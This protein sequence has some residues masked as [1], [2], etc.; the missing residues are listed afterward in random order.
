MLVLLLLLP[1]AVQAQF[2][3]TTNM[4]GENSG[5]TITGYDGPGG[6][7][8][9]PETINGLPVNSIE[10]A[11]FIG[12]GLTSLTIG[13]NLTYVGDGAFDTCTSLTTIAVDA[14]NSVYSSLGGVLFNKSQT[15]LLQYPGG[16]TGDY[17]IPSTVASIGYGAF[18][19]CIGVTS[20]T[21]PASVTNI[22]S[23]SLSG[24]TSLTT[25]TVEASNAVYS[26][27][28]GVLFNKSQTLLIQY[29][30]GQAGDYTIPNTVTSIEDYAF[31]EC[32]ALTNITIPTT[33]TS[34]GNP[35]FTTCT[36]LTTITVDSSNA[37]YSSLGGVLFNKSQTLLIQYPGGQAGDYTIPNTVT[38]IGDYAFDACRVLTNITVPSSVI[39]IGNYAFNGCSALTGITI[40]NG[41]TSIGDEA[42]ASCDSLIKITIPASVTSLGFYVFLGSTNLT[43]VYFTGNVP[44]SVGPGLFLG[45]NKVTVYYLPG[46]RGWGATFGGSPVVCWNPQA[47]NLG[48]QANQF[49]FNIT[50]SS[51]L[52]I[53]VEACTD[54]G[55]PVWVPVGTN[56]LTGG[57]STFSDPQSSNYPSRFYRM[58]PP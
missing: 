2:T 3:Y 45:D 1:V 57:V 32:N 26:S 17:T 36:S 9:I 38:S 49:G 51:N 16:R 23:F 13:T 40:L 8:T 11:A 28:G 56:T 27:L 39:S 12:S 6:A 19:D 21:I 48:V 10:I 5:I 43:S 50:G 22:V 34:I 44:S 4:S 15:T 29:P 54:L 37:V 55:N 33:V 18:G 31:F 25:I 41:V 52:V 58:R 53:V 42:F 35:A 30:G 7:E 14:S 46:T 47:Q 20:V 24:C